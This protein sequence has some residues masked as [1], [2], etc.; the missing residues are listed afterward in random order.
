MLTEANRSRFA[1]QIYRSRGN[2]ITLL[3]HGEGVKA[4][5][6]QHYRQHP[7][8]NPHTHGFIVVNWPK[9]S[10]GLRQVLGAFSCFL[11]TDE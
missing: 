11:I 8:E 7:N 10:S 1:R 5:Y 2:I 3:E 9:L 6:S 4:S